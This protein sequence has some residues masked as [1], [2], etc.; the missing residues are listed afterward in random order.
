[1]SCARSL[2]SAVI[3]AAAFMA[4][5]CGA[6]ADSWVFDKTTTEVRF[7]YDHFG[8]SRQWGRLRGIEGTLDFAPTDPEQGSVAVTIK[9]ASVSTGV[10]ELDQL[11]RSSDFFDAQRQPN[12]TFRSSAVR[13]TGDKT[14][15]VDGDL[16]MLGVTHP[17]TLQ[18]TW[19]FTGEYPLSQINPTYQG[20]WVSGFSART[21]ILRSA[22]GLKRG[23]PLISDEI[24]IVIDAEALRQD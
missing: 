24:E 6:S 16:T 11:L 13:Q 8:L 22:W 21:K 1:M 10:P 12:I 23:I 4:V 3:L 19:N 17:V 14:G 2:L 20:K 7:S 9:A 5:C 18:V 15:E